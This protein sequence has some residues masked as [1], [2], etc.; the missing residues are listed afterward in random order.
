MSNLRLFMIYEKQAHATLFPITSSQRRNA[1][2]RTGAV[3][4]NIRDK[5]LKQ[6]PRVL[7]FKS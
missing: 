1:K 6:S 3:D 7:T 2:R 4:V 5:I